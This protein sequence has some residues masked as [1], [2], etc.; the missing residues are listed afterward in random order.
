MK[1]AKKNDSFQSDY[2]A[3]GV[4]RE[5]RNLR[6]LYP[7]SSINNGTVVVI[8]PDGSVAAWKEIMEDVTPRAV[9]AFA[10][11]HGSI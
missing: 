9:T 5:K 6:A 11:R 10:M 2:G 4:N 1:K 7:A 8:T 3:D